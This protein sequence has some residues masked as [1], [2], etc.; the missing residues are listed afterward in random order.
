[1]AGGK[2]PG[3]AAPKKSGRAALVWGIV[4]AVLVGSCVVGVAAGGDDDSNVVPPPTATE[5]T[6][7]VPI[8]RQAF[9]SQGICYGWR[10]QEGYGDDVVSAGSNLGDGIPVEDHPQCPRWV[11]VVAAVTYTSESSELEDYTSVTVQGSSD[12]TPSDLIL[13]KTALS[14]FDLTDDAFVDDPGWA[15]TRAAVTL[16]LL[17]AERGAASPEPVDTAAAAADPAPLKDAGSDLWRDRWGWLI[18]AAGLLLITVLLVT[19]GLVLRR[20]QR[21]EVDAPAVRGPRSGDRTSPRTP[22][23]A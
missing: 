16:P 7:T 9:E 23:T 22:E 14:R 19:V 12:F 5:R 10:L 3:K 20:R 11:Q 4:A 6:D 17:V 2:A 13:M 21:R 15:V 1:M 8:L 18:G